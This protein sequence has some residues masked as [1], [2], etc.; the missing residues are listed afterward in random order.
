MLFVKY[1]K[2]LTCHIFLNWLVY[3]DVYRMIGS[4]LTRGLVYATLQPIFSFD[5]V[6]LLLLIVKI[7]LLVMCWQNGF[8]LCLSSL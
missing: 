5:F 8:W 2:W 4:F 3:L 1:T 7:Q 6:G